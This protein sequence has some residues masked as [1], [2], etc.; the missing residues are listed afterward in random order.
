MLDVL[1]EIEAVHLPSL[2]ADRAGW[3]SKVIDYSPPVVW[4][5]YRDVVVRGVSYRVN[6]HRIFPCGIALYHP[7]PWAAA[8]RVLPLA[9]GVTYEMAV[10]YGPSAGPC[11]PVS[12]LL[13]LTS[14]FEYEMTDPDGWHHV[15]VHGPPGSSSVSLMVTSPPWTSSGAP[16]TA[17]AS[18]RPL[19]DEE[20]NPLFDAT[21]AWY[22]LR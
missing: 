7:H 15:R 21:A 14:G 8:V 20:A 17:S 1:H 13:H 3:S 4:R 6:L 16:R 12:A 11:P 10:G 9:A 5:L 18:F 2:L 22:G 19:T